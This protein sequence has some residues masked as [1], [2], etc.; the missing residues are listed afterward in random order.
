M[1][2]ACVFYARS[3]HKACEFFS[4]SQN[5]THAKFWSSFSLLQVIL[6]CLPSYQ[7]FIITQTKH[8]LDTLWYFTYWHALH[9]LVYVNFWWFVQQQLRH[10]RYEVHYTIDEQSR[11]YI[12][13][14]FFIQIYLL[15]FGHI[16]IFMTI[17]RSAAIPEQYRFEKLLPLT[18]QRLSTWSGKKFAGRKR[19]A[20]HFDCINHLI[21]NYP[22]LLAPH[23]GP[24]NQ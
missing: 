10:S 13:L 9:G 19:E 21:V 2:C 5:K 20:H 24:P 23:N 22:D 18:Q 17:F 8:Y 12:W 1:R 16:N 7:T 15:P 11:I 14:L 6:T 3:A 4:F